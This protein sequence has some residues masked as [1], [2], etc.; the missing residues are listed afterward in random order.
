MSMVVFSPKSRAL[1]AA[2]ELRS[3][4]GA[5]LPPPSEVELPTPSPTPKLAL[6]TVMRGV[7]FVCVGSIPFRLFPQAASDAQRWV[8][9]CPTGTLDRGKPLGVLLKS[10]WS[11]I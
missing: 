1:D 9:E 6:S 3:V 2:L 7:G 8:A 4:E 5:E 11:V 10:E